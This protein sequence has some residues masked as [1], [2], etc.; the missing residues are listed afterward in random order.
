MR[1]LL[2]KKFQDSD[3]EYIKSRL[4]SGLELIEPQE[5][6]EDAVVASIAESEVLLG[7][8][9]TEKV[10]E[11]S[12]HIK[13]F[14]IPW[15]GVDAVDFQLLK[16]YKIDCVCNSH[17]NASVVAEHAVALYGAVAKKI[18]Y[19]DHQM[20]EGNW[21]RISPN[22]NEI[23]P[24]SR[25]MSNQK[26]VFV[27][28]GSVNRAVH[29]ILKGF[30]PAVT[31]VNR[32]GRVESDLKVVSCESICDVLE[33]T[34]VIFVAIPLTKETTGMINASCFGSMNKE[35]ILINVARGS[36]ICEKS[37]Y[38]ALN[39]K[40]IYG[41]GIDTWY[42]YPRQGEAQAFPSANFPFQTL[43]NLVMSPHRAGYINSGFPHLDDAILNLNNLFV[44][45]PL[46][47]RVSAEYSY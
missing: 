5:F 10:V 24:F 33:D 18:P 43:Q 3:I 14:Q 40:R 19:H 26:I 23:D 6:T 34:D 9:L 38:G 47:N 22:G 1:V 28:Y 15:T 4:N 30:T 35:S 20:R 46:I 7:G 36:V 11:L 31:I 27:G 45:K 41:A 16:K 8:M 12:A 17:S 21:N 32:T 2:T 29:K 39:E 37:L 42:N 44:G 13:L 25:S